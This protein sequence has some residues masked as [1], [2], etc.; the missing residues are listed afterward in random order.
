MQKIKSGIMSNR[1]M[2]LIFYILISYLYSISSFGQSGQSDSIHQRYLKPSALIIP[3][4]VIIYGSL[5]PVIKG[6]QNIDDTIYNRILRNH[7]GFH[8]NVEG[9]LMWA[10]SAS[11]YILDACN[12]TTKHTFKEHLIL[13]AGSIVI[14]G[15]IGFVMRQISSNI[16]VYKTK[17]TEFPS[18]HTA[19]AFRGAEIWHQELKDRNPILSYG[20]YVV[21]SGVGLLRIYNK[22]HYLTE[23]L[24]GA[25][26]GI[27]STKITYWI[28]DK[29]KNKSHK[30][31]VHIN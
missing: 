16:P 5:K 29:V 18:G 24:A 6:I 21:A 12:V 7:A 2:K 13:D 27:I 15:G 4:S 9:Y 31:D 20:G 10:P 19:N 8:T 11:I 30:K 23:V 14:T 1:W 25:G 28:F 17:N 26:L 3:G 22:Q